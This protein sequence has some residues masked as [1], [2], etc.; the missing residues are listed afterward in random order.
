ML[1]R[2]LSFIIIELLQVTMSSGEKNGSY[3]I[4]EIK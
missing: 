4:N 3:Q 2:N 1:S